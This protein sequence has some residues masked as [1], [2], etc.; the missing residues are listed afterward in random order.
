MRYI[1]SRRCFLFYKGLF[2]DIKPRK[3]TFSYHARTWRNL[4][5]TVKN[6]NWLKN[7]FCIFVCACAISACTDANFVSAFKKCLTSMKIKEV[8]FIFKNV[9]EI[10]SILYHC[11]VFV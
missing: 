6:S 3:K 8:I 11:Y 10:A 9:I 7:T 2:Q 1:S 4:Q 5:L